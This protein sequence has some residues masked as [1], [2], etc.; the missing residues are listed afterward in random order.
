MGLPSFQILPFREFSNAVHSLLPLPNG[1]DQTPP[2]APR[3]A[4]TGPSQGLWSEDCVRSGCQNDA[5]KR[6]WVR[7]DCSYRR[8]SCRNFCPGSLTPTGS[9][10]F[11]PCRMDL[12]LFPMTQSLSDSSDCRSQSSQRKSGTFCQLPGGFCPQLF[13]V[14]WR[15]TL[16]KCHVLVRDSHSARNNTEISGLPVTGFLPPYLKFGRGPGPP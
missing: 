9:Y 8:G 7:S 13:T 2:E 5:E 12:P 10:A 1:I 6:F 15:R 16:R 11:R 3:L 14:Q 4:A